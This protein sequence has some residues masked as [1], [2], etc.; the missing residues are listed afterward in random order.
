M[1]LSAIPSLDKELYK[2]V[3]VE[4]IYSYYPVLLIRNEQIN[5]ILIESCECLLRVIREKNN[6]KKMDLADCLHNLPILITENKIKIPKEFWVSEVKNY[7]DKWD[8]NFLV[9]FHD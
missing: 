6:E 3:F 5:N 9:K 7:R 8:K 2:F 1:A 4:N